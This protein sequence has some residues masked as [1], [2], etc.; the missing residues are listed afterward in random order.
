MLARTEAD[1]ELQ[2]PVVSE[3][4]RG[5]QRPAVGHRHARQQVLDQR[6]LAGAQLVAL[7]AA[8]KLAVGGGI[9]HDVTADRRARAQPQPRARWGV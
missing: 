5:I 3:Q 4:T 8:I 7:A 9:D 2:R 6:G 1:L